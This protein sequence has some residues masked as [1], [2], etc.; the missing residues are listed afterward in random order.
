MILTITTIYSN[1]SPAT[2]IFQKI[3]IWS[4]SGLF[5]TIHI[6]NAKYHF[7]QRPNRVSTNTE[8]KTVGKLK[9]H[10]LQE[11]LYL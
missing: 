3:F 9:L 11:E 2:Q 4:Q 1:T 7:T 6:K 10:L 5:Q 8:K